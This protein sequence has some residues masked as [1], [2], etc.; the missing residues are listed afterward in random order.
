MLFDITEE[1]GGSNLDIKW[2]NPKDCHFPLFW[3]MK[4]P[5]FPIMAII[6]GVMWFGKIFL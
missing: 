6:Y 4:V 3:F 5:S 2:G 1:R